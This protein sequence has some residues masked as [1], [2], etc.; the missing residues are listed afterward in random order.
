MRGQAM[1]LFGLIGALIGALIGEVI[2]GTIVDNVV[3]TMFDTM[4]QTSP[5]P[6]TANVI[7]NAK[8]AYNILSVVGGAVGGF[9]IFMG[10]IAWFGNLS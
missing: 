7:T 5:T 10:I 8:S 6:I 1:V 2:Y 9:V 4:Y 3:E